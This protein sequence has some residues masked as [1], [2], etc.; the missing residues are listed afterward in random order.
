LGAGNRFARSGVHER[1]DGESCET[2]TVGLT[3]RT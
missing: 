1:G 2:I 3:G